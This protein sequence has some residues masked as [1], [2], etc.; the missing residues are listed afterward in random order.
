LKKKDRSF[1]FNFRNLTASSI[2][3]GSIT[4]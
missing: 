4:V 2:S 3:S 1:G